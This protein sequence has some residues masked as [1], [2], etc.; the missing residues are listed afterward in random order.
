MPRKT[1]STHPRD[2]EAPKRT[3]VLEDVEI[4]AHNHIRGRMGDELWGLAPGPACL[5][6][7]GRRGC[8]RAE[9][10]D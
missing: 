1:K 4:L 3:A 8:R 10:S 9:T 5:C 7:H 2:N 6:G